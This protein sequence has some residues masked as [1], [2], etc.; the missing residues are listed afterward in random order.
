MSKLFKPKNYN[1]LSPYFVVEQSDRWIKLLK[2]IFDA[3]VLRRYDNP[4]GSL[5]H[6][7]LQIDDSVIM[8]SEASEQYPANQLLIHVYVTDA[9]K[10]YQ[11]AIAAGCEEI[12]KPVHKENDPDL[13]GQ[14]KDYIGNIWAVGTQ[15]NSK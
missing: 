9:L 8:V 14:F 4:D 12:E 6:A 10:V 13:R 11:K 15:K 7:E 2:E 3:K 5:M 1:S